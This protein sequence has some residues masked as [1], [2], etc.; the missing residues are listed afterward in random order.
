VEPKAFNNVTK[1]I[2]KEILLSYPN[3][4]KPFEIHTDASHTQLGS[5]ISEDG[6]LIAFYS[7]KLNLAQTRYTTAECELLA[8]VETLQE[9][10]HIRLGQSIIVYTDH[11]NLTRQTFNT[12][13]VMRWRLIIEEY[14]PEFQ[15]VKGEHNIVADALS[16][17]GLLD[18]KDNIN[19]NSMV[20]LAEC[21]GATTEDI[22]ELKNSEAFPLKF[23]MIQKAQK[24]DKPPMQA[25]LHD[26]SYS[27]NTFCGGRK[28]DKI[29]IPKILQKRIIE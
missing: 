7:R 9:F 11:Q 15:Y 13:R 5:V 24:R 18:T 26:N 12:E 29:V 17:L 16:R 28:R 8:V 3:F 4:N 20:A 19:V 1:I 6:K 25:A 10:C 2:A 27:L 14:G 22:N 21:Y 23:S